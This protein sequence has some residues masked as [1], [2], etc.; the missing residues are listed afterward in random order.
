[1]GQTDIGFG[2]C[3]NGSAEVQPF[4][5]EI[6]SRE[7]EFAIPHQDVVYASGNVVLRKKSMVGASD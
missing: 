1:M 7:N 3:V 2:K 4:A 5:A 6:V